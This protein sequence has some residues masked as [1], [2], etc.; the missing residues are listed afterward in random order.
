MTHR[1]ARIGTAV[2]TGATSG[3]GKATAQRLAAS[4]DTLVL[5][6]AEAET[7]LGPV[8]SEIARSGPAR[9][10]YIHA[11][12]TDLNQVVE[13]ARLIREVTQQIDLLINN[14]GLPGA[15]ERALTSDASERTLQVNA[16]APALLTRLLV[17]AL[18]ERARVVNVGSSAHYV[19]HFDFDD[20]DLEHEYSPVRAYARSKLAM[21]TWSSLLAEELADLSVRAACRPSASLQASGLFVFSRLNADG[22]HE[23]E[24]RKD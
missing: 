24:Q 4:A 1:A 2:L 8:L 15:P 21:V 10:R 5:L 18:A 6:G 19:E 12:F 22:P 3:I 11:D 16:L 13:A 14:A 17:P 20:V 23:S 9:V 7:A